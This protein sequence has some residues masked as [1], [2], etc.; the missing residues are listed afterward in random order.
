[1]IENGD[2]SKF[3]NLIAN[4]LLLPDGVMLHFACYTNQLPF[5]VYLVEECKVLPLPSDMA[6]AAKM[7][8]FEVVRYLARYLVISEPVFFFCIISG[9][10]DIVN[11]AILFEMIPVPIMQAILVD[12]LRV[13]DD[14]PFETDEE[15]LVKSHLVESVMEIFVL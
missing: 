3:K 11:F 10:I 9:C 1:M 15:K 14:L 2:Q 13:I 7:G 5:V 8:N 6:L 12:A 4:D